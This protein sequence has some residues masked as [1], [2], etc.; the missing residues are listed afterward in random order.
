VLADVPFDV[1]N[2]RTYELALE[3]IGPRI[4]AWVDGVMLADVVDGSPRSLQGGAVGLVCEEGTMGSYEVR[5]AP[6]ATSIEGETPERAVLE[7]A[8]S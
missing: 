8:R 4:R 1:E 7:E 2:F 6:V 5:V 3:V